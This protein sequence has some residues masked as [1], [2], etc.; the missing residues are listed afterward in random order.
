MSRWIILVVTIKSWISHRTSTWFMCYT[1]SKTMRNKWPHEPTKW[2][3]IRAKIKNLNS[4]WIYFTHPHTLGTPNNFD[5]LFSARS[6]LL[7][8][9]SSQL[10]FCKINESISFF[11]VCE[12]PANSYR[13]KPRW[14]LDIPINRKFQYQFSSCEKIVKNA[15]KKKGKPPYLHSRRLSVTYERMNQHTIVAFSCCI[16]SKAFCTYFVWN[17]IDVRVHRSTLNGCVGV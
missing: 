9:T 15:Q 12:H 7:S 4:S 5:S 17:Y 1:R 13:R 16:N 6:R 10:F 14:R 11:A 8:S 3:K 2:R